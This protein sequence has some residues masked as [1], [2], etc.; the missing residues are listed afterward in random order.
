MSGK[1][2]AKWAAV[3]AMACAGVAM[4][5]STDVTLSQQPQTM[6]DAAPRKPLMWA[7]DQ[8]GLAKP[9]DDWNINVFGYI[10]GSVSYSTSAPPKNIITA[11]VFDQQHE[12]PKMNQADITVERTV[13]ASKKQWDVGFRMEWIYGSD[14][15]F[16]HSNGLF[17]NQGGLV[18]GW[19]NQFDLNQAYVDV[20]AP[21]G[22]GLRIRA[23]K[24]V[25]LAGYETINPTTTPLYNRGLLF[26]FA[27]PFTQTGVYGTY[28]FTDQLTVDL[29][30]D[31]GWDQTLEDN[32]GSIEAFGRVSWASTDKKTNLYLLSI[33]GPNISGD[34]GHYRTLIDAIATYQ[35]SDQILLAVNGDYVY[36]SGEDKGGDEAQW[37]GLA[38]YANYKINDYLTL[39]VRAEWFDDNDGTRIV[40]TPANYYEATAG[41]LITPFPND[42]IGS[43]WKI[44]PEMR[45]DYASRSVFDGGTDDYQF[46]GALETYFTY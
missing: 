15:R 45:G 29:G 14:S 44:R 8:V 10:E 38:G 9:L 1:V 35:W 25:T 20:A 11:R 27:I 42:A 34:S 5:A 33:I 43:N 12:S 41:L 26:D 21:L 39:N 17:D 46:T 19:E 40:A 6:A 36:G 23:G 28:A 3:A 37:F 4:A 13:D 2:L 30:I 18:E 32:N 16:I 24:F 7:L 31:R 22:N